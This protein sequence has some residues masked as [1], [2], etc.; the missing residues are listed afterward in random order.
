M[1]RASIPTGVSTRL[2][3]VVVGGHHRAAEFDPGGDAEPS[4]TVSLT[5]LLVV[6]GDEAIDTEP[7]NQ[8][9]WPN[10]SPDRAAEFMSWRLLP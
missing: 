5:H 1:E 3:D 4:R 9:V 10:L 2:T 6:I 7:A 8:A